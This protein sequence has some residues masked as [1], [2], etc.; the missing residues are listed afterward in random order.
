M[1]RVIHMHCKHCGKTTSGKTAKTMYCSQ[2]CKMA[3]YRLKKSGFKKYGVLSYPVE[4]H[5]QV[6]K[7]L[8]Q[9]NKYEYTTFKRENTHNKGKEGFSEIIIYKRS[10]K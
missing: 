9:D 8:Q 4:Q 7:E 2:A 10:L 6:M 5:E 1:E 3:V